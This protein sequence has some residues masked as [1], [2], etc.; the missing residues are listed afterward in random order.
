MDRR[1]NGSKLA[2]D[3]LI[4]VGGKPFMNYITAI[5]TQLKKKTVSEI[6][7]SARGKFISKAVD[8]AES[9]KNKFLKDEKISLDEIKTGSQEFD[10]KEGKHI[11][12]ST[13]DIILKRS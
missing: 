2:N 10:T 1:V 4:F 5:T 11:T 13:I 8:V 7:I 12:V 6:R 9:V 3:N